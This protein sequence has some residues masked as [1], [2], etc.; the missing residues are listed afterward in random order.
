M[1]FLDNLRKSQRET[2]KINKDVKMIK[3]IQMMNLR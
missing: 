3:M 2:Q 1:I